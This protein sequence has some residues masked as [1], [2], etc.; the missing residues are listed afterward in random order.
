MTEKAIEEDSASMDDLL[1][2]CSWQDQAAGWRTMGDCVGASTPA[3]QYSS[4]TFFSVGLN[5]LVCQSCESCL[6]FWDEVKT[7]S[8]LRESD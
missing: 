7:W 8:G 2:A 4:N 1:L 5:M 6:R 3:R